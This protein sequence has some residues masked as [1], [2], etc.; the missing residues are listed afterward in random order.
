M[1]TATPQETP[2]PAPRRRRTRLVVGLGA[3]VAVL[4]AVPLAGTAAAADDLVPG[5][6]CQKGVAACVQ[7]GKQG[8][9][10]KAWL[11][12]GDRVARGPVYASTGGPGSDTP[13]GDYTVT[14]KE[15]DHKSSETTDAFG[16]ASDMPYSVFFGN[17]GYAFHGG[18]DPKSRTAGC[19][20]L[21]D[22]DASYF[23]NNLDK[24]DKVE[25]V[26]RDAE[27][28]GNGR[29]HDGGKKGGGI[30]GGL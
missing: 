26:G 5:T 12:Q 20:R 22:G 14:R 29:K 6:P 15:R 13:V 11:I 7:L 21:K 27:V 10:A 16:A 24:G 30:L 18:G 1:S 19:V 17:T 2:R 8:F 4:A 3:A 9:D 25:V 23:F 28:A